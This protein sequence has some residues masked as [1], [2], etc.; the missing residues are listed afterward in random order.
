M[1]VAPRL[2]ELQLGFVD[3]L[4]GRNLSAAKW[5]L[6]AGLEP[7]AR[8]RIYEHSVAA[9]LTAALRDSFPGVLALVGEDFFDAAAAR[10]RRQHPSDSG[11]L[12]HF[13]ADFADFIA[14]M[15]EAAG[16]R[17]LPD[18]ARLEWCRQLAALAADAHTVDARRSA[19]VVAAAPEKLRLRLH[20]SAHMLRSDYA[21]LS[22][23][24]WCQSPSAAAPPVNDTESVLLWRDGSDVSMAALDPATFRCIKLLARG[25]DIAAA[26]A[27]AREVDGAFDLEACLRD[28]LGH[29]LVV[30][31]TDKETS[32]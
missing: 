12:Q 16:L 14:G 13:G 10:Y 26:W 11:N 19:K 27:G 6:G 4:L 9:T 30:A 31:F 22:L 20:P 25:E 5:V 32:P 18:V 28:L 24:Q 15:P 8:L 7:A 2:R 17:Y 1:P 3:A 21:V 23:W 29:G